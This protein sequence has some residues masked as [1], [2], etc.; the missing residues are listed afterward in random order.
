MKN[1]LYATL[2]NMPEIYRDR[3]KE[4]EFIPLINIKEAVAVGEEITGRKSHVKE[5]E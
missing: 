2:Q 4:D 1:V 3:I 5:A